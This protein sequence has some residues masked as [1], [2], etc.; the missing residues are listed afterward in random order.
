MWQWN[1]KLSISVLWVQP[2]SP[3]TV[4]AGFSNSCSQDWKHRR[5]AYI[6][7]R[8]LLLESY[9]LAAIHESNM[10]SCDASYFE[11]TSVIM[12]LWIPSITLFWSSPMWYVNMTWTCLWPVVNLTVIFNLYIL[13]LL[14]CVHLNV[15][16][17]WFITIFFHHT[18]FWWVIIWYACWTC[19]QS[20]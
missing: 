17:N 12:A 7:L 13:Q 16:I 5:F 6:V 14:L 10:S 2:I 15:P 1:T 19:S 4:P 3:L 18:F 11:N 20:Y 8:G 9:V